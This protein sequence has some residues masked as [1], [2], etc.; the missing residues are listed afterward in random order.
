MQRFT[1]KGFLAGL[2][3]DVTLIG[4][5]RKDA[6]LFYQPPRFCNNVLEKF[7]SFIERT[8]LAKSPT[9]NQR[10]AQATTGSA[11]RTVR[12]LGLLM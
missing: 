12:V 11:F 7:E 2:P 6:K 1:T 8:L 9:V 3:P 10:G 5:I 4:R